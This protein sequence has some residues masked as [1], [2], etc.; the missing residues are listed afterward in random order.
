MNAMSALAAAGRKDWQ[1]VLV[2]NAEPSTGIRYSAVIGLLGSHFSSHP[3]HQRR[4][5][6]RPISLTESDCK[7]YRD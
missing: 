2:C 4:N 1:E 3:S 7:N 6:Q 5:H